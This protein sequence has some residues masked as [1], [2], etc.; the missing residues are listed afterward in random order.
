[1]RHLSDRDDHAFCGATDGDR[2]FEHER[3]DC[4]RCLWMM[5]DA[6][7]QDR[8]DESGGG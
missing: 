1:M 6:D 4:P 3:V 7:R 8:R 5:R 2:T